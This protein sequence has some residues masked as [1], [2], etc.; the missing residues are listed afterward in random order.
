MLTY[1]KDV[2]VSWLL[3]DA[4]WQTTKPHGAR[5]WSVRVMNNSIQ[6]IKNSPLEILDE[7]IWK[8]HWWKISVELGLWKWFWLKATLNLNEHNWHIHIFGITHTE[9][10]NKPACNI[11]PFLGS[12]DY[13]R[14]QPLCR[15]QYAFILYLNWLAAAISYSRS[16]LNLV[17][18]V[19]AF[20][21]Q[22]I[23]SWDISAWQEC[24]ESLCCRMGNIWPF[25]YTN[26]LLIR[27]AC[28][29]YFVWTSILYFRRWSS[30]NQ[31]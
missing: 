22:L 11:K 25:S 16:T 7:E 13:S 8:L 17:H 29:I 14:G 24:G 4:L 23:C 5:N 31:G 26:Q 28:Q 18:F 6:S 1:F 12:C 15:I 20:L 9:F 19:I 3:A 27:V 2:Y 10:M 21:P 30:T